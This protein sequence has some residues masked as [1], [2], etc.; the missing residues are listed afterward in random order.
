MNSLIQPMK[1]FLVALFVA[2]AIATFLFAGSVGSGKTDVVDVADA[3]L[4]PGSIM[5]VGTAHSHHLS[6]RLGL[7][8]TCPAGIGPAQPVPISEPGN[9]LLSGPIVSFEGLHL[10]ELG[11]DD[12]ALPHFASDDSG[13]VGFDHYVQV[14]NT[15]IAVY[16]KSGNVL[17]GPVSTSTFWRDQPDCGEPAI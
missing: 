4:P 16:D 15:A 14:V 13:A 2:A 5:T 12:C 7:M 17:A 11:G 8:D 9:N 6:R 1:V 3:Q 10:G